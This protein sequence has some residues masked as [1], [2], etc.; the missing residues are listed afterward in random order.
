V[1]DQ[2]IE[3]GAAPAWLMPAGLESWPEVAGTISVICT[4]TSAE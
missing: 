2:L 1:E 4:A 3:G